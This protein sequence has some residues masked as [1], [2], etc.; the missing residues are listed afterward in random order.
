MKYLLFALCL[1]PQEDPFKTL[2]DPARRARE[3]DRRAALESFRAAEGGSAVHFVAARFLEKGDRGWRLVYDRLKKADGTF[4][5]TVEGTV[6]VT[7]GGQ[8]LPVDSGTVEKDVRDAASADIDAFLSRHWSS[9][10]WDEKRH[11]E[12][13][14]AAVQ[15]C[16]KT[17]RSEAGPEVF[18]LFALAH[19]SAL[20]DKA[21]EPAAKL[22]FVKEEGLWGRRDHLALNAVS[23]GLS[24]ADAVPADAERTAKASSLFGSRYGAALYEVQKTLAAGTGF[25]ACHRS[26]TAAAGAGAPRAVADHM[27]ALADGFRALVFCTQCKEGRVVCWRCL[28]KKRTDV[29]CAVCKGLGWSAKG[30][31]VNVLMPC[32]NCKGGLIFRNVGCPA[33]SQLGSMVCGI[34]GGKTWREGFKGCRDCRTCA[35]CKGTKQAETPCATCEGK[36]RV[37]PMMAGIP[38]VLCQTCAGQAVLRGPCKDCTMS[39]LADCATCGGKGLRDGKSAARPKVSD[40]YST[41]PCAACGGKGWPLPNLAVPCGK[42]F[43]LGVRV[44]PSL[45][46]SKILE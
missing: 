43:G 24:G 25:E 17:S 5:G 36:G 6:L 1:L 38:T 7:F 12:A 42:C 34:C 29:T 4:A 27:K 10:S 9:P 26:L 40:L 13:L 14:E 22:G 32:P 2:A 39:G 37:P 35:A 8:R 15:G 30:D 11:R 28:G 19:L 3:E 23:R 41:D 46:P 21:A 45:D 18:R 33:C 31:K 20:G 44:K 16:E